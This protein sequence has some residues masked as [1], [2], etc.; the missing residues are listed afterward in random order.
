[1]SPELQLEGG[2]E[3]QE[4]IPWRKGQL[5]L[6]HKVYALA[7]PVQ[8]VQACVKQVKQSGKVSRPSQ[9]MEEPE[10]LNQTCS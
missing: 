1:M 3:K 8:E 10:D 5:E 6:G 9:A 4:G 7:R 2:E